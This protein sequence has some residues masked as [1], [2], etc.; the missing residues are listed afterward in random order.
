MPAAL[1]QALPAYETRAADD[2][3]LLIRGPGMFDAYLSPW[4]PR[5]EVTKDGWFA[6]GDFVEIMD[7]GTIVMHG[8][9]KSVINIGGMKVFP[10][11]IEAVLNTHPAIEKSRVF[12]ESHP[13]LGSYPA[14]E[15]IIKDGC[16]IPNPAEIRKHCLGKLSSYKFPMRVERVNSIALTASGKVK[17]L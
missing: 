6:T 12:S 5:D 14:A 7:D 1:G 2:G 10:E 4:Q 17:R 11:E 8:R 3:E 9:K 16:E 15:V 13:T